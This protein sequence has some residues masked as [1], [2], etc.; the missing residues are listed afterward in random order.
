MR[1][2]TVRHGRGIG[3]ASRRAALAAVA[4][5][6]WAGL[7]S[8]AGV[9]AGRDVSPGSLGV[10]ETGAPVE[11]SAPMTVEAWSFQ[12]E[13]GSRIRTRSY[14][15]HTTGRESIHASRLPVFLEASLDHATR[16]LGP[17]PRPEGVMDTYVMGTR[18]QWELL[19]RQLM[20]AQAHVY[21]RIPRGGFAAGGRSVLYDIGPHDTLAIAA[22]EGWHQYTQTVFRQT[23]PIWLEEGIAAYMEGYQWMPGGA[24]PV[25]LPWANVERFDQLRAA[26]A[27]GRL[28]SLAHLLD[29]RPQTLLHSSSEDTLTYY[30][31]VWALVHFLREGE[32]G[33]HGGALSELVQDAA[34]GRLYRRVAARFG[35]EH[36]VTAARSLTGPLV[37]RAYFGDDVEA[38]GERY[39]AF[40][41]EVVRPGSRDRIVAGRS[42]LGE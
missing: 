24:A 38:A 41:R 10:A 15:L 14:R 3:R 25:F 1:G 30:A 26:A 34:G 9:P 35:R 23:M 28:M 19:T 31:Q 6:A 32:G 22:H 37:F 18:A 40:V 2:V 13:A 29:A 8:C 5:A 20:G 4:A 11:A 17:L 12:G 33:A 42:P 7:G 27:E 36:A 39:A 21:L 16:A